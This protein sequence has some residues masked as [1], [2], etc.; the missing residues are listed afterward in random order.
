MEENLT[1]HILKWDDALV[2][3][4]GQEAVLVGVVVEER[5]L[6][7]EPALV[8]VAAVAALLLHPTLLRDR[9]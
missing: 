6:H 9:V 1:H 3:D 2:L 7:D 5:A 8:P 4:A